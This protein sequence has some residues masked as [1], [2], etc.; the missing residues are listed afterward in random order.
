M[1]L[2]PNE[3]ADSPNLIALALKQLWG[4]NKPVVTTLITP[5]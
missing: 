5:L 1:F 2:L 4:L 3:G